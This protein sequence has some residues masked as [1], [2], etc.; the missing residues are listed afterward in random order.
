VSKISIDI[1]GFISTDGKW[2]PKNFLLTLW[3]YAHGH[4]FLDNF[5]SLE[6]GSLLHGDFTEGVDV[7]SGVGKVNIVILDL[8]FLRSVI[9]N[10]FNSNKNL[11]LLF[12][13]L[14]FCLFI[15][16]RP[17]NIYDFLLMNKTLTKQA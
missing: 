10:S 3:A 6:V 5:F 11:H 12:S 1:D 13:D 4:N 7:Q 14:Y 8:N 9:D 2:S 17:L 16:V 15:F